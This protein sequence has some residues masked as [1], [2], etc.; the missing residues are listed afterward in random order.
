MIKIERE[1]IPKRAVECRS[2]NKRINWIC[3]RKPEDS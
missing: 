3:V 1:D 2:V